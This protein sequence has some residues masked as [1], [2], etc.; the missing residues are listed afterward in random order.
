MSGEEALSFVV[1]LALIGVAGYGIGR[2]ISEHQAIKAHVARYVLVNDK[3]GETRFEYIKPV[4]CLE[5]K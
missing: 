4:E 3:T 5:V 1:N 2:G